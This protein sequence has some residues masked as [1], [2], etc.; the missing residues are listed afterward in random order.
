M[1]FDIGS[2]HFGCW[3]QNTSRIHNKEVYTTLY[4]QPDKDEDEDEEAAGF[5]NAS[6]DE[7]EETGF[8][9]VYHALSYR[10][11]PSSKHVYHT[12][13]YRAPPCSRYVYHALSYR[14]PPCSRCREIR[15]GSVRRMWRMRLGLG[16]PLVFPNMGIKYGNQNHLILIGRLNQQFFFYD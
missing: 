2:Q 16:M 13:S 11:L 7:D 4:L 12:L 9:Y 5:G 14:A 3:G 8:G 6:E 10:A 15:L 1:R